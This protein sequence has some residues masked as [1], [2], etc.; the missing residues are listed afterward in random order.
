LK[1]PIPIIGQTIQNTNERAI[2][3]TNVMIGINLTPE[4]KPR[5]E[6]I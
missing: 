1:I 3:V 2:T 5:E 6:G 4:K